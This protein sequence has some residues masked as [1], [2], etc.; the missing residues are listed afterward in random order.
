M[1]YLK[2]NGK[3]FKGIQSRLL[4]FVSG[5][6]TQFLSSSPHFSNIK[7]RDARRPLY[8]KNQIFYVGHSPDFAQNT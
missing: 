1:Q 5:S 2:E 7:G 6:S 3:L 4:L 8:G